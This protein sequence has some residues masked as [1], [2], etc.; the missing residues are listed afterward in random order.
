MEKYLARSVED[1]TETLVILAKRVH[2]PGLPAELRELVCMLR[3][4]KLRH[5]SDAHA[6]CKC[7]GMKVLV[8]LLKFCEANSRDSTA[9]LGTIG[10]LCA[11]NHDS[12]QR[13]GKKIKAHFYDVIFRFFPNR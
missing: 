5:S 9:V 2:T 11:L 10:N 13:V 8:D 3:A 6:F 1:L 12:R 7:G 4:Q